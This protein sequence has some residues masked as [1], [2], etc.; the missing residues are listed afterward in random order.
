LGKEITKGVKPFGFY[1]FVRLSLE[2]IIVLGRDGCA[3]GLKIAD[4]ADDVGITGVEFAFGQ[5]DGHVFYSINK[6]LVSMSLTVSMKCGK[7]SFRMWK[8]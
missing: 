2:E 3:G 5:I 8:G 6:Y 4:H 7:I 1:A